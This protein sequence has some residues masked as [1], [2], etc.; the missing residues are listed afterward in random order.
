MSENSLCSYIARG[1]PGASRIMLNIITG[2]APSVFSRIS[3][4]FS[5]PKKLPPSHYTAGIWKIVGRFISVPAQEI[6]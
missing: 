4:G 3:R 6:V 5:G 2:S 1:F